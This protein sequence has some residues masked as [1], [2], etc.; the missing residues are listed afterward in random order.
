LIVGQRV[1]DC[2]SDGGQLE[3][4]WQSIPPALGQPTTALADCGYADKADFERLGRQRPALELYVSV[5]REDAHAERRYD[6]RPLDRIKPPKKIVDP[7]LVAMADKLKTPEGKKLY[8][9][10]ACTVEPVFGIIKAALGF[11]QFLLRGM[12]QVSGEWSLVCLAYN[13]RRL[14]RLGAGL[15]LALAG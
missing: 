4:D 2:A 5:H 1:S 11:R 8:R 12:R 3:P 15:K 13:L 10:R 7:V 14:H 6:Y 9:Q